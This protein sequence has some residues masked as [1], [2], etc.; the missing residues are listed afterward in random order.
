MLLVYQPA[1]KLSEHFRFNKLTRLVYILVA[2]YFT[3]SE[4]HSVCIGFMPICP[5]VHIHVSFFPAMGA[6]LRAESVCLERERVE[7]FR[8]LSLGHC[9]LWSLLV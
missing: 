3:Y 2:I 9:L 7:I 8:V 5:Y 4:I 1:M 6:A